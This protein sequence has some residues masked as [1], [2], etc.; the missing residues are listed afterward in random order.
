MPLKCESVTAA[1]SMFWP[2][3]KVPTTMPLLLIGDRLQLTGG[4]AVLVDRVD[5][6]GAAELANC[7]RAP[8]ADIHASGCRAPGSTLTLDMAIADRSG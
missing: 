3:E 5:G 6:G 1:R 2:L 8:D 7:V 4:I